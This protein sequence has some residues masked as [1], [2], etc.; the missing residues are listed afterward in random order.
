MMKTCQWCSGTFIVCYL[1]RTLSER[2]V[3][4]FPALEYHFLFVG[5]GIGC[6]CR[7]DPRVLMFEHVLNGIATLPYTHTDERAACN[8]RWRKR[9]SP[10][11]RATA[12]S[13]AHGSIAVCTTS[14]ILLRTTL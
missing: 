4:T 12:L 6:H 5:L 10:T 9:Q 11:G 13:E 2:T 14:M 1:L 7:H 3:N 8:I